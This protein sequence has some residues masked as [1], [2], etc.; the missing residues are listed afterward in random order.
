MDVFTLSRN[1]FN[2]SFENPELI[3]PNHTAL[4]FFCIEHCNRLGWKEKFGLPTTMAKDAIGIRSYNTY[5]NTLNDLVEWGF[6][7]MIEK[8]KNQYSSNIVALSK[9][10]KALDK[11]L[12]KA[13][14]KHVTKQRESI[15]SIDI[16]ETTEQETKKP[17]GFTPFDFFGVGIEIDH[18]KPEALRDAAR[19]YWATGQKKY[20]DEMYFEFFSHWEAL[21]KKNKMLWQEQKTF[22][23][24]KRLSTWAS[25]S[26]NW[27]KPL[28]NI[29]TANNVLFL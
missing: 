13:I 17:N 23:L 8:S 1:W 10:D 27:Q 9:F 28:S 19:H 22:N 16:Q 7:K 14:I 6:I 15:S 21:T 25:N 18:R 4:Y 26:K 11:A 20:K 12:D 3:S 2:F 29:S 24:P 5:I